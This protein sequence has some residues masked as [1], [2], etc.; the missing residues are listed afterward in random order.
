MNNNMQIN[1]SQE[2]VMNYLLGNSTGIT[3]IH[4]KAGCGKTYLIREIANRTR[5]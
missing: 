1:S 3:F 2:E 5:G 4:G